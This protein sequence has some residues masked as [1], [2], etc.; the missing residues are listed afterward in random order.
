VSDWLRVQT[1]NH[2][3][4]V[5]RCI[6]YHVQ[7]FPLEVFQIFYV[8]SGSS[9]PELHYEVQIGLSTVSVY[10]RSLLLAEF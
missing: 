3:R 7:S 10:M 5:P 9:I 6:H 1:D 2:S 4:H 8:E